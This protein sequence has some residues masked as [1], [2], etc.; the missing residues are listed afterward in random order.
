MRLPSKRDR[1]L[2]KVVRAGDAERLDEI[3]KPIQAIAR[4]RKQAIA[5]GAKP[6]YAKI[7]DLSLPLGG[8]VAVA[9]RSFLLGIATR[10]A[11]L[12]AKRRQDGQK[13]GRPLTYSKTAREG[14]VVEARRLHQVNPKLRPSEIALRIVTNS[15]LPAAAVATVRATISAAIRKKP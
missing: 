6:L 3:L 2:G 7:E 10:A 15:R 9:E 11:T 1:K 4:A 8:Q 14:W 12:A 5:I 13:G